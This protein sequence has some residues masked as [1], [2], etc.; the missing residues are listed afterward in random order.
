MSKRLIGMSKTRWE[1]DVL[2]D[3]RSKNVRN[4]KKVAKDRDSYRKP[5]P[6]TGYSAL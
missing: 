1:H 5:Q 6:Y 3:I 2:E 4:L